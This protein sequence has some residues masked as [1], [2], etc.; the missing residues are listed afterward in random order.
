MF[1]VSRKLN[2]LFASQITKKQEEMKLGSQSLLLKKCFSLALHFSDR[3]GY[4]VWQNSA[5]QSTINCFVP[6]PA[7]LLGSSIQKQPS[8]PLASTLLMRY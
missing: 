5:T 1:E 8:Y 4:P 2:N 6:F 3:P 7:L